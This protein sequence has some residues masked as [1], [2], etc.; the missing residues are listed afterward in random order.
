MA[1]PF[2]ARAGCL[3]LALAFGFLTVQGAIPSANAAEKNELSLARA[4]FQQATEMEQAG[5]HSGAL[6]LFREVG[7][8][9]MTPQVRFH[10]AY[11]EQKLGKLVAALGGYELALAEAEAISPEFQKEVEERVTELRMKIPKLVIARGDGAQTATIEL[12][13]V[14]L[15]ESSIGVEVPLDPG[16]HSINAKSPGYESYES[17]ISVS[18]QHVERVT[19]T[20]ERRQA[21]GTNPAPAK[22]KEPAVVASHRT[23]LVPYAIG[24]GAVAVVAYVGAAYFYYGLQS[25]K[26][27]DLKDLCGSDEDCTNSVPR[28]LTTSELDKARDLQSKVRTYTHMTNVSLVIGVVATLTSGGLIVAEVLMSDA[29]RKEKEKQ[30]EQE[31]QDA[32]TTSWSI[33]PAAPGATLGGLSV[34]GRF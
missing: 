32:L 33:Q 4:K 16:P 27:S 8:V 12:D 22:D 10:I 15:G 20:L 13:G 2:V 30:K 11:C 24:A 1:F 25:G 9:R 6:Q 5:N 3:A 26:A 23:S 31:R 14:S 18:E 21:E 7:Q 29:E 17:T 28:A 34:V 19:V